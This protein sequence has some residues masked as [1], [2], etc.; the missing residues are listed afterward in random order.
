MLTSTCRVTRCLTS[1]RANDLPVKYSS[2][3]LTNFLYNLELVYANVV[4]N[5]DIQQVFYWFATIA[6]AMS[7]VFLLAMVVLLFYIKKKVSDLDLYVK[8]VIVQLE[9]LVDSVS[10]PIK[11]VT[12]SVTNFR[13]SI[14]G[15]SSK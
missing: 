5:M 8:K 14:L 11:A 6:M 12:N 13:T 15:K 7:I 9:D 2:E 3:S 10:N 4:F 1:T